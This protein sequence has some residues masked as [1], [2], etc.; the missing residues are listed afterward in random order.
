MGADAGSGL[1]PFV[2]LMLPLIPPGRLDIMQSSCKTAD[3]LLLFV[4]RINYVTGI[5]NHVIIPD[6]T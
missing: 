5:F 6:T 1:A 4:V 3:H 2:S